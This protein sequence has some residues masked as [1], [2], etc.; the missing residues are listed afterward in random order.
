LQALINNTSM[1]YAVDLSPAGE[2][3]YRARFYFHPNSLA[4]NNNTA[5]FIFDGYNE[6]YGTAVFRLELLRENGVYKLRPRIL[7]DNWGYTNG[8]KY[9]ISNAWHAIEIEWQTSSPPGANNG[10]LALWI[11]NVLVG[12]IAN[13][14]NDG[15]HNRLDEIRLGATG[16]VDSTTSGTM[17]F[18]NFESRRESNIG[19]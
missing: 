16:G 8:S 6:Y 3:R 2:T 5:H 1:L 13:V 10:Y 17:Y 11:D 12:T 14:D 4:M 9:T 15:K 18:D 19:P 7:R